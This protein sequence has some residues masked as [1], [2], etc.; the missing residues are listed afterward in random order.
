MPRPGGSYPATYGFRWVALPA[1]TAS[2][3]STASPPRDEL[4]ALAPPWLFSAESDFAPP[5]WPL[6]GGSVRVDSRGWGAASPPWVLAHFVCSAWPGSD[7]RV[8]AMRLW[9]R[10]HAIA[11]GSEL[12]ERARAWHEQ[13]RYMVGLARPAGASS[14]TEAAAWARLVLMAAA[15]SGRTPVL[16]WVDC[17][18]DHLRDRCVWQAEAPQ[19]EA[20]ASKPSGDIASRRAPPT[21]HPA[22]AHTRHASPAA[23]PLGS[24]CVLRWP[25][26]C[27]DVML[28]PDEAR[29]A[30]GGS[31]RVLT[32]TSPAQLATMLRAM[33]RT[34][35]V[36]VAAAA[37]EMPTTPHAASIAPAFL[38]IDVGESSGT[39]RA[40]ALRWATT[41]VRAVVRSNASAVGAGNASGSVRDGV[42][43]LHRAKLEL[44][45][46]ISKCSIANPAKAFHCQAVC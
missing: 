33:R 26:G 18:H 16:P 46:S 31:V 44:P 4:L 22:M 6:L 17:H 32:P 34:K 12:S 5:P 1:F 30:A 37:G 8:Q 29:E 43:A 40:T 35:R 27:G 28:L 13:R 42:A 3:A 41:L 45:A 2:A 21:T 11:I 20:L 19:A 7:G 25:S 39:S 36:V 14:L 10:W 9:R 38:L 15:L 23:A 24:S